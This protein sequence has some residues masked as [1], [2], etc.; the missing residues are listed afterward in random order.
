MTQNLWVYGDS[1]SADYDQE[2]WIWSR[3]LA[4]RFADAG[5]IKHYKNAS[6]A[7][8]ANDWIMM[9]IQEDLD[10][11]DQGDYVI[12]I[13]TETGRQWWFEDAPYLSNI[14]SMRGSEEAKDY[15]RKF[16]NRVQAVEY[17]VTQLWRPEIDKLRFDQALTWLKICALEKGVELVIM[18]AFE[19]GINYTG[20][21][22]TV[23]SLTELVSNQEFVSEQD[24]NRWYSTGVDTRYNHMTRTNHGIMVDKLWDRFTQHTPVDLTQGFVQHTLEF[25]HRLTLVDELGPWLIN[26]AKT[27]T[28]GKL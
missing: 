7:G 2:E 16:P 3:A 6:Q 9:Q 12:V 10:R 8:A 20:V 18:P 24:M 5:M 19:I 17:Y 22:H 11:W 14:V 25:K 28:V 13:P 26:K 27:A 15:S 21:I 4:H 1:F 23:G